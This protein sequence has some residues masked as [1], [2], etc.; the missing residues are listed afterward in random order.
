MTYLDLCLADYRAFEM[1]QKQFGDVAEDNACGATRSSEQ[2]SC[3]I[4]DRPR[5]SDSPGT[6]NPQ[7]RRPMVQVQGLPSPIPLP[8]EMEE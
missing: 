8:N 4:S 6:I 1:E 5:S 2:S 7:S 3:F